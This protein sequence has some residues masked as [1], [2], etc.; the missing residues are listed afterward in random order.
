MAKVRLHYDGWLA[1][2][3]GVRRELGVDSGDQLKIELV[4]GGVI[5]RPTSRADMIAPAPAASSPPVPGKA[6]AATPE[7]AGTT[8]PSEPAKRVRGRPR[9]ITNN[10]ILPP[11]LKSRGRRAAS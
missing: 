6:K 9:N 11:G 1:L 5:L 2:P 4:V 10:A 3:K 8:A 7:P